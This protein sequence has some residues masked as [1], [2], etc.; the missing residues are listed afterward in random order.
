MSSWY[1]MWAGRYVC[2]RAQKA[3]PSLQLLL[4]LVTSIF[5]SEKIKYT[6]Q[7]NAMSIP[8]NGNELKVPIKCVGRVSLLTT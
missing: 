4:K 1:G 3:R 5:C 7:N 8:Q 6:C 2:R